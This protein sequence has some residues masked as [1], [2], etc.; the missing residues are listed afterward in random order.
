MTALLVLPAPWSPRSW[1]V[2]RHL[3]AGQGAGFIG[4]VLGA[5][6]ILFIYQAEET[7]IIY[8]WRD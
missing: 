3:P 6:L 1:A 4:A 2:P 7:L 8:R 5:V